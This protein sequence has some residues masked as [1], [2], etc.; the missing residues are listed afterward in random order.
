MYQEVCFNGGT[1]AGGGELMRATRSAPPV[2]LCLLRAWF[3]F[4]FYYALWFWFWFN[5]SQVKTALVY[6][7]NGLDCFPMWN[8]MSE[9]LFARFWKIII[10]VFLYML[11]EYIVFRQFCKRTLYGDKIIRSS[12]YKREFLKLIEKQ[13]T[14]SKIR[15]DIFHK[16]VG[17][18]LTRV[19]ERS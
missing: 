8:A 16:S 1:E 15:L 9:V 7:I 14:F 4:W 3:W 2:I 6:N 17:C 10:F 19:G 11:K 12:A 5:D 18:L 13:F